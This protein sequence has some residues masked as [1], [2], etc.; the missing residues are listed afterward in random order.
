MTVVDPHLRS[1]A[2]RNLVRILDAARDVFAERG[3]DASVADVAQRAEVGTATIFRRFPTK[4][5][6]CAAVMERELATTLALAQE[7]PSLAEFMSTTI[8]RFVGNRCL[9]EVAGSELFERPALV[10]LVEKLTEALARLLAAEQKAGTVRRDVVPAD[11]AFFLTAIGQAGVRLERTAP[12]AWRRYLEL[13][14]DGLKPD[15]AS[16]LKHKAPTPQQL[17]DAKSS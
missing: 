8:E 4:D 5:D 1:D 12:G 6:L 7:A 16:R 3:L 11:V 13:V 10:E 14:L 2:A 9:C 15:G 17:H